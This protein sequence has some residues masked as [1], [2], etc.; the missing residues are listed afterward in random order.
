[1]CICLFLISVFDSKW[2]IEYR[3]NEHTVDRGMVSESAT[4]DLL[5]LSSCDY[6]IGTFTSH[7]SKAAL[8]MMVA[9]MVRDARKHI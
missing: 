3:M 1:M 7:F 6:L 5:L 2:F 9:R 8:E 4:M